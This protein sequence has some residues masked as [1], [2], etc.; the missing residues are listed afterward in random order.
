[1]GPLG[2]AYVQ[3]YDDD[4]ATAPGWGEKTFME[5]YRK[6][7]FHARRADAIYERHGMPFALIMRSMPW[8]CIDI[9]G[10]NG[11]F[12]SAQGL[13]LPPTLAETSKS[14]N[15]YHLFYQVEDQWDGGLGFAAYKD[16]IGFLDGIDIRG[17][18]CV[19]HY[20][21]QQWN[22]KQ[23]ALLPKHVADKLNEKKERQALL[24]STIQE[25]MA[26]DDPTELLM[27]QENVKSRLTQPIQA[28]K[29]NNTLFAIGAEMML[30]QIPGWSEQVY[31]RAI[32]VG[33]DDDEATKLLS[34]IQKYGSK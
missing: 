30:A 31:D 4:G 21:Q 23:V 20:P 24:A 13:L 34:N 27:I 5:K 32:E 10:K 1:M 8:I 15:G 22:H 14:G 2:P 19:Y 9:D 25:A 3:V 28:G 17:T 33:L 12:A 18:G 6:R 11:G 26:S 29:R 16:R 7:A